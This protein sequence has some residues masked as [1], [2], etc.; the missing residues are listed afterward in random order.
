MLETRIK[1]KKNITTVQQ[2]NN[3]HILYNSERWIHI[4][5]IIIIIISFFVSPEAAAGLEQ[6]ALHV[7]DNFAYFRNLLLLLG[8]D[9]YK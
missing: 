4:L 7:A 9:D 5:V 3:I 2:I 1:S 6:V 8:S